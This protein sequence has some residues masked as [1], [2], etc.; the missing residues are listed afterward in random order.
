MQIIL[1]PYPTFVIEEMLIVEHNGQQFRWNVSPFSKT[2]F[3]A[4]IGMFQH[5]NE[6]WALQTQEH[7]QKIYDTY[8]KIY[9]TFDE[10]ADIETIGNYLQ[11]GI[12]EL[13]AL[14]RKSV[15]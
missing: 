5:I 2:N 4:Q 1:P 13:I 11:K 14:D 6:W 7:Q 15:V 12:A 8:T 9:N 10:H 3:E